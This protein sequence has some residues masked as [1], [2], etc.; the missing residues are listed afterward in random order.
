MGVPPRSL[1]PRKFPPVASVFPD[2]SRRGKVADCLHLVQPGQAVA[3]LSGGVPLLRVSGVVVRFGGITAL[4]GVSFE[5]RDGEICGLIGPNGSGKTTL[6]NCISGIYRY[7][8]GEIAFG[9][10][11]LAGV[12]RHR[13]A[14]LGI[15]RTF[16]NVA[17]FR[18]TTVRENV[19][20]GAHSLGRSGFVAN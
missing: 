10:K 11:N 8:P 5:V 2:T 14:G 1:D 20:A 19:L 7:R 4:G 13:I 16:Q 18:S 15:G 9:G 3:P 17:L 6:F 12:R